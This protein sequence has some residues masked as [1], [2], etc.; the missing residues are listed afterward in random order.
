[1]KIFKFLFVVALGFSALIASDSVTFK[2]SKGDVVIK[3]NPKKVA[4]YD[5][6]VLD[7]IDALGVNVEVAIATNV[8]PKNLQKY[9]NAPG[10]GSL[11]EPNFE[12]LFEFKPDVI[13]IGLRTLPAYEKLSKIAP[14]VYVELDYVNYLQSSKQNIENLAKLFDKNVKDEFVKLEKEINEVKGLAQNSDKKA[15][16]ILTN[17]GKISAY[18]SGSRFGFLHSDL[19][20]KEADSNIKASTHGQNVNYEYIA[21]IN[22][23]ILLFVDRTSVVGGSKFG[24]DTLNNDLVNKTKAAK[25]GKIIALNADLWYLVAGGLNTIKTQIQEIKT[26]LQ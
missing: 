22:P 7:T 19:G 3:K 17:D 11:K 6:G 4:I 10:I 25:N 26:A 2:S 23:D 9:K 12:K 20:I 13:F 8:I 21:K 16:V 18:G 1:M 15:L 14:T 5:F 24:K